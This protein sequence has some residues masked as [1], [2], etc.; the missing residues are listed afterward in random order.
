MAS[1]KRK[2]AYI[3]YN[4][5]PNS[6]LVHS[7]VLTLLRHI[8]SRRRDYDLTLIAIW[9]PWVFFLYRQAIAQMARELE[10][11]GIKLENR[12]FAFLPGRY[13]MYDYRRLPF[14][15]ALESIMFRLLRLGRFQLVH[16]RS[17]LPSLIVARLKSR[18]GYKC[19]FDMR[20]LFPEEY[21]T[22]GRWTLGSP[23]Y[24]L[25]KEYE[26]YTV[27]HSDSFTAVSLPM[28]QAADQIVEGRKADYIPISADMARFRFDPS[29]R[30]EIRRRNAWE[31]KFV[32]AYLGSLGFGGLWN[33]I[34]NYC[35]YYQ[36][37]Q[38]VSD[39][40]HMVFLVPGVLD[41]FTAVLDQYGIGEDQYTFVENPSDLSEWLS[42]ADAGIHVMSPGPDGYTRLGVKVV[43]YLSAGLPVITNA[44][45]G[46]AADFVAANDVGIRLDMD[47]HFEVSL[48]EFMARD[49]SQAKCSEISAGN[50]SIE[51]VGGKYL[52][53][54]E[55]LD[56]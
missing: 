3:I 56:N 50:F 35:R 41:G 47:E 34:E 4:D 17:Y 21:V 46:A 32:I 14:L 51:V 49:Y 39:K 42:A 8:K 40:L 31:D 45:V 18:Y 38:G 10:G 52:D 9:Q 22:V 54:Y 13:F 30:A 5:R 33:N 12:P 19:I 36:R 20:S 28:K 2:I 11:C 48:R 7:Q 23:T 1:S 55:R 27:Q 29:K 15:V 26:R 16:C 24:R 37:M 43:E 25:W 53:L 44:N 6:G